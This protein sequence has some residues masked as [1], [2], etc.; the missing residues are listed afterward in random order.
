M[1][2]H[3]RNIRQAR[4]AWQQGFTLLE[5]LVTIVILSI[6]LL[7]I[8]GLTTGVIRGNHFSKNI[9]SATAA[10][11]TQLE[12]V[13]SGG[14]EYALAANFPSDTVN[15]GGMSFNRTSTITADSPATNMKTVSVTVNWTESNNT[16]R[17]VTL[18]TILARQ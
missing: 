5:V 8:A 18:E 16:A 4:V 14:Y 13:K 12:A 9:T 15:M 2:R 17:S 11:Q 6:G 10:A 1:H 3:G 7:G